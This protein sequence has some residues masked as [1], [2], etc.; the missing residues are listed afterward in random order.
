MTITNLF[1]PRTVSPSDRCK[2]F[3][4]VQGSSSYYLLREKVVSIRNLWSCGWAQHVIVLA[5][6]YFYL[7]QSKPPSIKFW[8]IIYYSSIFRLMG[9]HVPRILSTYV[10]MVLVFQQDVIDDSIPKKPWASF[11]N[12]VNLKKLY[13]V[14][15]K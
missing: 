4:R 10:L 13:I 15:V 8:L 14:E 5:Y 9:P 6:L 7:N 1:D 3:C 2:L 11:A 12:L